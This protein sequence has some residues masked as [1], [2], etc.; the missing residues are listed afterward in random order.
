MDHDH[1]LGLC[2]QPPSLFEWLKAATSSQDHDQL[3]CLPL[4]NMLEEG[5]PKKPNIKEEAMGAPTA[6]DDDD[7]KVTVALQLGLPGDSA[8]TFSGVS[9]E[10]SSIA[11]CKEEA[12]EEEEEEEEEEKKEKL[13]EEMIHEAKYWIPTPTQILIGPVQFACHVCNKTF[14]RYNNMQVSLS[15]K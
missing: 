2:F 7:Q 10:S 14:N 13:I 4:I 15:H 6:D 3:Q 5:G 9:K 12:E 11:Y 8:S 1:D